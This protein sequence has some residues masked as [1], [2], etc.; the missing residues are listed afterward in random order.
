MVDYV[1]WGSTGHTRSEV[2]VAASI[3]QTGDF[4][5]APAAG[6]SVLWDGTDDSVSSWS[7]GASNFGQVNFAGCDVNAGV[8]TTNDATTICAGD[9][10]SDMVT[11]AASGVMGTNSIFVI[12][13]ESGN[14]MDSQVENVFDF[15]AAGAGVCLIWH[16]SY[17][18]DVNLDVENADDL[19]GCF[20]LSNAIT[21]TRIIT[22]ASEVTIGGSNADVTVVVNDGDADLLTFENDSDSDADYMYIITDS[23]GVILATVEDSNDFEGSLAGEC[24]VYG[25]SYTGALT[26]EAGENITSAT[27]DGCFE[28]T[29]TFLTVIREIIDIVTEADNK[30]ITVYPTVIENQLTVTGIEAGFNLTIFSLSGQVVFNERIV[31][32]IVELP[33]FSAGVYVAQITSGAV[34]KSFRLIKN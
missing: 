17:E 23:D 18:D 14:L 34:N 24:H 1:E 3:W 15:D 5:T 33:S 6:M 8:I 19:D 27:S 31:S 22:D 16:L 12:T 21:I 11:V 2:A 29:E 32:K 26:A 7:T 13:D 10:V 30:N 9:D 4:I 28:V 20:S 25:I